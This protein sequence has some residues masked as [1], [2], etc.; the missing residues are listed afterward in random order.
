MNFNAYNGCQKC[1]VKGVYQN[2]RMAFPDSNATLR[3]DK[4]FRER[5]QLT[6]HK[7]DSI[8]EELEIDMIED[9]PIADSLHL[10]DHGVSK[11]LLSMWLFGSKLK[12]VDRYK[13]K[14]SKNQVEL[15]NAKIFA[16]N[17]EMSGDMHRSIRG[18]SYIKYWKGVE[19]RMFIL[20]FG[21]VIFKD[22]L[23]ID[24]YN[25]LLVLFCA[26]RV[27]FSEHY[28]N[29]WSLS[30]DLFNDFVENFKILYGKCN[31]GS[32][33]HNLVHVYEDVKKF[34]NLNSI[35]AYKFENCLGRLKKR[36]QTCRSPLEQISRRVIESIS[37][38]KSN[39]LNSEKFKPS[40]KY[41]F[42]I[43]GS[44]PLVYKFIQISSTT[45]LS[46][47]HVSDSFFLTQELEIVQMSFAFHMNNEFYINGLPFVEKHNF[48]ER[49]FKSNRIHVFISNGKTE[50]NKTYK[51]DR[52]LCKLLRLNYNNDYVFMP[53]LHSLD[54]LK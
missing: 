37:I 49:P 43:D 21:I 16:A 4:S 46:T 3:S 41:S 45:Y 10:I 54:E 50:K 47:K 23:P 53:I 20:N 5:R 28:K 40:L 30:K 2:N 35:S 22:Y 51:I 33:V 32:N 24:M 19:F 7:E 15:I 12:I 36:I 52:I 42:A 44:V 38:E 17:K 1:E 9:F 39:F 6:H 8:L 11:K 18:L 31:I 26:L 34:G 29:Y 25:H 13:F 27:C 14:F 48:F